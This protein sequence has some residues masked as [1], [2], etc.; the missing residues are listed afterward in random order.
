[1]QVVLLL[2][3]LTL[4]FRVDSLTILTFLVTLYNFTLAFV[5]HSFHWLNRCRN[6]ST[7]SS[8]LLTFPLNRSMSLAAC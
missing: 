8:S 1:M 3:P 6:N 4:D 5:P 7:F 2:S